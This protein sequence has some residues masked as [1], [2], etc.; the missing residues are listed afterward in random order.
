M[1]RRRHLIAYDIS[2]DRRLRRV[3]RVMEAYGDRLQYSVF[4]CDLS[5]SELIAW[6]SDLLELL[7]LHQDSVVVLDL[8]VPGA[9]PIEMIGKSRRLPTTGPVIV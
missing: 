1:A 7:D 9:T 8:G 4:I 2:D 3:A 5:A 6:R